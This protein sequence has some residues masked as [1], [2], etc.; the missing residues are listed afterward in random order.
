MVIY[1]KISTGRK[2]GQSLVSKGNDKRQQKALSKRFI[3][4]DKE[5]VDYGVC[6]SKSVPD[7]LGMLMAVQSLGDKIAET[8]A[9]GMNFCDIDFSV[10]F[11]D[12]QGNIVRD[13]LGDNAVDVAL[14][15]SGLYWKCWDRQMGCINMSKAA[16][17]VSERKGAKMLPI[18]EEADINQTSNK[19]GMDRIVYGMNDYYLRR[20]ILGL[21]SI[22]ED[23]TLEELQIFQSQFVHPTRGLGE[24]TI[25]VSKHVDSVLCCTMA[26]LISPWAAT[27]GR[28]KKFESNIKTFRKDNTPYE[29]TIPS[30]TSNGIVRKMGFM[31]Q[32][33]IT[34][35][36]TLEENI[37][38]YADILD[39][40][41][42]FEGYQK[43]D[44]IDLSDEKN[45]EIALAIDTIEDSL[46]DMT[47]E[48]RERAL[49]AIYHKAEDLGIVDRV[50]DIAM[51]LA[52]S[53]TRRTKDGRTYFL[54]VLGT[55]K[56]YKADIYKAAMLF[57]DIFVAKYSD[58]EEIEVP[59]EYETEVDI[60]EGEE[61]E[62]TD[63][64]GLA[65][66]FHS[67]S[68]FQNG[69]VRIKDRN[70]VALY[71]PERE[72]INSNPDAIILPVAEYAKDNCRFGDWTPC[73]SEDLEKDN[74]GKTASVGFEAVKNSQ[75]L[76]V[77][78]PNNSNQFCIISLDK[79]GTMTAAA[80]LKDFKD[81]DK[82]FMVKNAIAFK[83]F[84]IADK[85]NVTLK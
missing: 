58:I 64:Y 20:T 83:A 5:I 53:E 38:R 56:E 10:Y 41:T 39:K 60:P 26:D 8:I 13:T 63:G 32:L 50:F 73:K 3:M 51:K 19:F 46:D 59:I 15:Y 54:S 68:S 82:D 74:E 18:Y 2:L 48:D 57:G 49:S 12:G 71:N 66:H 52:I 78:C 47:D 36:E 34:A 72:I 24:Q 62:I 44:S 17:I 7:K 75:F 61:F 27:I 81:D 30:V 35:A 40:E 23:T 1:M 25:D 11:E 33:K 80:K 55:E 22:N 45:F 6:Y 85:M 31:G 14:L 77:V 16:E 76:R 28:V 70:V 84:I 21:S 29:I 67:L 43:Y 9:N 4:T 42:T 69:K 79:D 65:G 37:R